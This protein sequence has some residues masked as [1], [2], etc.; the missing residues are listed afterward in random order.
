MYI[1]RLESVNFFRRLSIFIDQCVLPF[2]HAVGTKRTR[3]QNVC[4]VFLYHY[5]F[6]NSSLS[7]NGVTERLTEKLEH[8][9]EHRR[10]HMEDGLF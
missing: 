3:A 6:I 10:K 8:I 9:R 2:E 1:S 5:V 4:S 7:V